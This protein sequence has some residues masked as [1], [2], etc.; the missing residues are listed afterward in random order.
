MAIKLYCHSIAVLCVL[1]CCVEDN[2]E[3]F[4]N[5]QKTGIQINKECLGDVDVRKFCHKTV[6]PGRTT[7]AQNL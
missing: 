2:G 4:F 5:K 6:Y 1:C 3:T 7:S